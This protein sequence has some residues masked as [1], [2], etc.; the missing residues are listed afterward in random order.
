[1]KYITI[2]LLTVFM[3]ING[4]ELKQNPEK[5]TKFLELKVDNPELQSEID[6]L[7]KQY[8]SELKELKLEFKEQKKSLRKS[9]KVRLKELRKTFKKQKTKKR[10]KKNN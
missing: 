6:K 8:D 4:Q 5:D 1:M 2:T 10:D 3:I 7:K 9:Y